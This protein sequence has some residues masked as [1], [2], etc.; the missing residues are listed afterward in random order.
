[1][2]PQNTAPLTLAPPKKPKNWGWLSGVI[3]TATLVALS[4]LIF[5][6]RQAIIDRFV[7]WRYTPS[8]AISSIAE[9]A[10]LTDSGKF[11]FYASTPEIDSSDTFNKNC[12]RQEATSAIL[13]CYYMQRIFLY[14]VKN[15]ETLS[16]VKTVT[17]AHEMLH[18]AWERLSSS[19]QTR[20]GL[21]LESAYNK[22]KTSELAT[23]M[24]Y[25]ARSQPGERTQELHSI[26]GT[27]FNDLG[28]ELNDYYARYF[29]DRTA[30]VA[31]HTKYSAIFNDIESRRTAL[32]VEIDALIIKLNAAVDA[33][34]SE[35]KTLNSEVAALEASR[36]NVDTKSSSE[37]NAFN[38]KRAA[39]IAQIN[40][41]PAEKAAIVAMQEKYSS[42]IDEYNAL[43]VTGNSLT[44]SLDS[45]LD[46]VPVVQ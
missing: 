25:Y 36:S 41:L 45:T 8:S 34:N 23:R 15:N 27:E 43:V 30:L 40:A 7:V 33:Y 17:A 18:A 10:T 22:V 5:T 35:V 32:K 16:G 21:L 42:L 11:Y 3:T 37:V 39:L 14:D 19:E 2:Q 9:Q 44:N 29:K 1:M 46:Q 31:I 26:L 12:V 28:G 38:R 24:E 4:F 20:L 6:Y 13:G